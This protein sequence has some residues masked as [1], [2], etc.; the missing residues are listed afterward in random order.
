MKKC[1]IDGCNNQHK[2]RGFCM[3]HYRSQGANDRRCE[4]V[5]CNR[6]HY[7]RGYCWKHYKRWLDNRDIDRLYVFSQQRCLATGCKT[8]VKPGEICCP[9]HSKTYSRPTKK[10]GSNSWNWN[11]GSSQYP[12]H[13]YLKRQRKAKLESV[14]YECQERTPVCTQRATETHHIDGSK[15]NHAWDNLQPICHQCHIYNL[16][17]KPHKKKLYSGKTAEEWA[18]LTGYKKSTV[19]QLLRGTLKHKRLIRLEGNY[20]PDVLLFLDIVKREGAGGGDRPL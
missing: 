4:I 10:G 5:A 7:A 19:G 1:I 17:G 16:R 3:K 9:S 14:N 2:A 12:N 18:M 20:T 8:K 6:S 13:S 15:D 11:G